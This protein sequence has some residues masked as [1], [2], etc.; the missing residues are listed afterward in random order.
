MPHFFIRTPSV[1][2][3]KFLGPFE[4]FEVMERADRLRHEGVDYVITDEN[5]KVADERAIARGDILS[6]RDEELVNMMKAEFPAF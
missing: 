6:P 4:P 5:G 1:S 2:G 3:D